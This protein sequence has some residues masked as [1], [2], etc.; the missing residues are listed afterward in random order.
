VLAALELPMLV[1][2]PWVGS[3]KDGE[4]GNLWRQFRPFGR[5]R[6]TA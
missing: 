4:N 6:K 3:V 1:S 5:E 2:L